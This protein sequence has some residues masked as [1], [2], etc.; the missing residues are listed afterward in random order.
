MG[1]SGHK[2]RE[3]RVDAGSLDHALCLQESAFTDAMAALGGVGGLAATATFVSEW[4]DRQHGGDALRTDLD[5]ECEAD[6][7]ALE[8]E[9]RILY[10]Q[11]HGLDALDAR[12]GFGYSPGFDSE[13]FS[14]G[15]GVE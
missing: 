9:N 14:P 7:R 5:A 10:A 11:V 12:D 4:V 1:M 6:R 3:A 15:F 13:D 8:L 2:L